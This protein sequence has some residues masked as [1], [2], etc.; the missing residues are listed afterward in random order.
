MRTKRSWAVAAVLVLQVLVLGSFLAK[1]PS[2]TP[3]GAPVAVVADPVI[4]AAV[5]DQAT[6][7]ADGAV[8]FGTAESEAAALAGVADGR[9]VAA[10]I[11]D[12]RV[13]Q[14][15][16]L[17]AS[18]NGEDL[19]RSVLGLTKTI[20]SAVGRDV[21]VE[22]VAPTRDG[23]DSARGVYLLIGACVLLGFIAPIGLTWLRGPVASTFARGVARLALV[24]ASAT[25]GGLVVAFVAAVR[26]DVG[27]MGWWL[28]AGLT[29]AASATVT[30]ALESLFGVLGIG[31]ATALLVLS[32]APMAQLTSP[33]MLSGPWSSITPWLPHG[34]ALDAARAQAY[35]GGADLRSLL[36]LAAWS[37]LAVL[38]LVVSRHER[39]VDAARTASSI[40]A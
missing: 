1:G 14:D 13:E 29:L 27:P 15:T 5:V 38:T 3:R 33:L 34:A 20:E 28:I 6:D 9:L 8:D 23:D 37:A 25:A 21:V 40:V 16:V 18:A 36:T 24:A 12:L 22:D 39:D 11:V 10:V 30:L 35:F 7:L 19:N 4:I 32:A 31:I 17:I 26:Y 2:P